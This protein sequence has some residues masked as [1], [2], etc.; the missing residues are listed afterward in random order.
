M[1]LASVPMGVLNP[2]GNVVTVL[3]KIHRVGVASPSLEIFK[4]RFYRTWSNLA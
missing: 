1:R 2:Y 3:T 4:A